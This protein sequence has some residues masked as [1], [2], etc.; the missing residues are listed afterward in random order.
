MSA[1]TT[2]HNKKLSFEY[3]LQK[4]EKVNKDL[5]ENGCSWDEI[6]EIWCDVFAKTHFINELK[7]NPVPAYQRVHNYIHKGHNFGLCYI[8]GELHKVLVWKEADKID[9]DGIKH[10]IPYHEEELETKH[11][12]R[13]DNFEA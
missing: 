9:W 6:H 10:H 4:V 13:Y 8:K 5:A 7:Q 3:C 1:A 2:M 12:M 11:F